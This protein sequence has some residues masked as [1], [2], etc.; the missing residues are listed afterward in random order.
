MKVPKFAEAVFLKHFR[1]GDGKLDPTNIRNGCIVL[2]I[3]VLQIIWAVNYGED[4]AEELLGKSVFLDYST[5][6]I[7]I[8]GFISGFIAVLG[9]ITAGNDNM[10]YGQLMLGCV[11]LLFLD[12][13]ILFHWGMGIVG[14]LIPYAGTVMLQS[15]V[16]RRRRL[17]ESGKNKSAGGIQVYTG[18]MILLVLVLPLGYYLS[19]MFYSYG[20]SFFVQK[21]EVVFGSILYVYSIFAGCL[22]FLFYER[23]SSRD[24]IKVVL[25][26]HVIVY[27]LALIAAICLYVS[28][29]QI[30][31]L[32]CTGILI[33]G[34][35]T[36]INGIL[37]WSP[38]GEAEEEG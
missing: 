22:G 36:N 10:V 21:A 33:A 8:C 34:I 26:V 2:L 11:N 15:C 6:L 1:G 5:N 31:P 35:G 3:G 4:L 18:S 37:Q 7:Q 14:G 9:F 16:E 23:K 27:L 19:K 24:T 17:M 38:G 25:S 20:H 30:Q 13:A 29:D 28:L 12:L 32:I